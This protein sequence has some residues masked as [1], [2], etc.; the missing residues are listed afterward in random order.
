MSY[1]EGQTQ[2]W[3]LPVTCALRASDVFPALLAQ[4]TYF[5]GDTPCVPVLSFFPYWLAVIPAI[6]VASMQIKKA[7]VNKLI[8]HL[9]NSFFFGFGFI[10][11]VLKTEGLGTDDKNEKIS[12]ANTSYIKTATFKCTRRKQQ[13][14]PLLARNRAYSVLT[15]FWIFFASFT[16]AA[17][18][19]LNLNPTEKLFTRR[20]QSKRERQSVSP[21]RNKINKFRAYAKKHK[22]F[23]VK[24]LFLTTFFPS[25]KKM[26]INVTLYHTVDGFS[27]MVEKWLLIRAF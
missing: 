10:V 2:H 15:H 1:N 13:Q 7:S 11:R 25:W 27:K 9:F 12:T 3:S 19:S 20:K 14:K 6:P 5:H 22:P 23:P 8:A 26:N 17:S 16:F 21:P 18:S 4:A 24:P